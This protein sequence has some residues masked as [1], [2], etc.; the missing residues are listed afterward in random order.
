MKDVILSLVSSTEHLLIRKFFMLMCL[1][2]KVS[3]KHIHIYTIHQLLLGMHWISGSGLPDFWPFLISGSGGKLQDSL[4]IY[5]S[6]VQSLCL[7]VI[8]QTFT[9]FQYWTRST[10]IVSMSSI[11][12]CVYWSVII[13]IPRNFELFAYNPLLQHKTENLGNEL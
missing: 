9:V 1:V 13:C 2:I 12:V 5:C 8:F 3:C 11:G 6:E 4:L 10:C 7:T